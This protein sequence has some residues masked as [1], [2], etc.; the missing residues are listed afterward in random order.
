MTAERCPS[1]KGKR[2]AR[3]GIEK[4]EEERRKGEHWHGFPAL[5]PK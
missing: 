1:K 3:K 5:T 2:K 4:R